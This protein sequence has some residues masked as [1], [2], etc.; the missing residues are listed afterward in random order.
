M[1]L[2]HIAPSMA[3]EASGITY[4]VSRLCLNLDKDAHDVE[5]GTLSWNPRVMPGRLIR[6]FPV[7]T[8]R[9]R[10]GYSP[11]LNRWL[12]NPSDNGEPRVIHAHGVWPLAIVQAIRIGANMRTPVIVSPH[13]GLSPWAMRHG[14]RT[15]VACWPTVHRRAF[16]SA[17]CFHATAEQEYLDIRRMGLRQ[18]VAVVPIGVEIADPAQSK[19]LSD[20]MLLFL[21]RVHPVKG[22]AT[23]IQAWHVIHRDYPEWR[24]VVAGDDGTAAGCGGHLAE[25]KRLAANLK[26]KRTH[27]HGAVY[28]RDKSEL[29]TAADLYVLP[30]SSDNFAVTVAEALAAGTPTVVAKGAPWRGLESHGAGWWIDIGVEPLVACLRQALSLPATELRAM[31]LR[32]QRWMAEEFSWRAVASEMASVYAWMAD[33]RET[34]PPCIRID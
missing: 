25:L 21:A 8:M 33:P 23:L 20:K 27:F 12:S 2:I 26:L 10:F 15:K 30:T 28:G 17:T 6:C 4:A 7:G 1:R 22:A 11:E 16:V 32:G 13:G 19:A 18:P 24:L 29:F 3:D 14:S 9:A 34:M 5:V 31:G